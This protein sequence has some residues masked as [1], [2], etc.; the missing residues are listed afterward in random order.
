MSFISNTSTDIQNNVR[1]DAKELERIG[2]WIANR[3]LHY[4]LNCT[5]QIM[6]DQGIS[7][8]DQSSIQAM[9]ADFDRLNSVF[10]NE[11]PT[12]SADIKFDC[13][14]LLGLY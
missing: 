10:N 1:N 7:S 13:A 9:I 6:G 2:D 3:L 12:G 11:A 14:K 8:T 5:Q 4:Q